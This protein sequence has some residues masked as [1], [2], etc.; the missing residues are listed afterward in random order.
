MFFQGTLQSALP[1]S[2]F[3][4]RRFC[5]DFRLDVSGRHKPA[6]PPAYRPQCQQVSQYRRNCTS[7]SRTNRPPCVAPSILRLLPQKWVSVN[8]PPT[9]QHGSTRIGSRAANGIAPSVIKH[10]PSTNAAF[11]VFPLS[12][13]CR[14]YGAPPSSPDPALTA[15]PYLRP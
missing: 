5:R 14:T 9:I 12:F 15:V 11:T 2:V 8:A 13:L 7:I 4:W 10:S 6:L 1:F 3:L